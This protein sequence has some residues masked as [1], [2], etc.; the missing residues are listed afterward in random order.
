MR[1]SVV[2]ERNVNSISTCI[3]HDAYCE[4]LS[5]GE[6]Q[7]ARDNQ[8]ATVGGR[9]RVMTLAISTIPNLARVSIH[10]S[11][12]VALHTMMVSLSWS[13]HLVA[14][15]HCV[16]ISMLTAL[17]LVLE[18][19]TGLLETTMLPRVPLHSWPRHCQL[20]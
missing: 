13:C 5:I 8:A 11:K 16:D 10:N 3:L 2:V 7:I 17:N 1:V 18:R 6:T 12:K 14:F 20:A 15:H 9:K 4:R 19:I